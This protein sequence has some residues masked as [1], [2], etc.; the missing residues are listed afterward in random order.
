MSKRTSAENKAKIIPTAR[1]PDEFLAALAP[2][3]MRSEAQELDRLFRAV[4]EQVPRLWGGSIVGYGE[5][6]TTYASGRTVHWLRSGFSPRK[7]R[8]SLYLMGGYC[9]DVA[10]KI[11]EEQLSRLGKFKTGKSCLYI[12]KLADVDLT[13]LEEIVAQDWQVMLRLYPPN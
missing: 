2:E 13:V 12:N 10:A 3:K 11:R 6:S 4:T 1:D 8:H 7:S 5:Y 9:D